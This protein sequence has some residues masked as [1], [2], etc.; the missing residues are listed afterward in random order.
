[1]S[2]VQ[3]AA[4]RTRGP[5]EAAHRRR[6]PRACVRIAAALALVIV[7]AGVLAGCGYSNAPL[8]RTDIKTVSV[9]VFASREFR[10]NLEFDLTSD[11]VRCIEL[12]TPYKVVQD[13]K[14]ADTELRG[15][16]LTFTSPVVTS[17]VASDSPQNFEVTI[18]CWF[19][20]KNLKTGEILKRKES[21]GASAMFAVSAGESLDSATTQATRRLAERIVEAMEK[22]W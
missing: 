13:P 15:E 7:A 1:M 4:C 11:L 19:E 6:R 10:R 20:W 21:I 16:I 22:P 8:H 14:V 9:P 17:D 2:D 12:R 5:T 18:T 3:T